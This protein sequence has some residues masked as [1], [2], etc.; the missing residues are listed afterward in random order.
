MSHDISLAVTGYA[1]LDYP[2]SLS[3]QIAGDQ[4]TLVDHRNPDAWPRVGGCPAFM[5]MAV[6]GQGFSASPLSWIGVDRDGE[7]YLKDLLDAGA[8]TSGVARLAGQRSPISILV[9]QQD[10]SCAC[11]FDPAFTD[12]ETLLAH[13][14]DLVASAS[15]LCVSVGPPQLMSEILACR[16]ASA[17]LY[18]VLKNDPHCFTPAICQDLSKAADVIFCSRSER[19]LV[20][21]IRPETIL[22]ETRGAG[23]VAVERG[24]RVDVLTTT[25]LEVDDTTGAGDTFAGGF[26]AAEMAG[27]TAPLEA[28]RSGANCARKMLEGRM[29]RDGS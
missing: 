12:K 8:D 3:G 18:W 10:G 29:R 13:Q 4:T 17:R 2:V 9:Y 24:G 5:A 14:R 20:A 28:A 16:S 21:G 19:A 11:L 6:A 22:V 7:H 27:E 26:V 15:H 1:S 25:P 23:G